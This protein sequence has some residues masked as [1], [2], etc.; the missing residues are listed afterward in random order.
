MRPPSETR[1]WG[2]GGCTLCYV[3]SNALVSYYFIFFMRKKFCVLCFDNI[4]VFALLLLT[5]RFLYVNYLINWEHK[6]ALLTK[7]Q[8]SVF[9]GEL[10]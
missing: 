1:G 8:C 10:N 6:W 7:V 3:C 5:F 2:G 4:F 9:R